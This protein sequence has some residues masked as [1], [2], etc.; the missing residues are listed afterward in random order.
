[1]ADEETI[2]AAATR[3]LNRDPGASMADL[4]KA[5]GISRAT[6]HRHFATRET[7]LHHIAERALD[8]WERVQDEAEIDD[9]AAS[10]DPARVAA[11]LRALLRGFLPLIDEHGF[12][13]T[14]HL[15]AAY[16]AADVSALEERSERLEEREIALYAAAQR[17]GVLRADL[18]ARWVSDALFGLLIGLRDGLARGDVAP[19]DIERLLFTTF[20]DGVGPQAAPGSEA[21]S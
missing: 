19:R 8:R 14:V 18:P 7:L 2:L 6:L 12:A 21:T 16:L 10:G 17:A 3:H 9:A 5:I 15:V 13:L 20:F 11:S 1:M 4:A